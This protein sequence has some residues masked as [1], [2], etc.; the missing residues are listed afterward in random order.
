MMKIFILTGALILTFT[1]FSQRKFWYIA[2][3]YFINP[4]FTSKIDTQVFAEKKVKT[5]TIKRYGKKGKQFVVLTK[6]FNPKGQ[7]ISKKGGRGKNQYS[8]TYQYNDDGK[9]I[10]ETSTQ[11]G[12]VKVLT[13]TYN[14]NQ[15]VTQYKITR[16][17][18]FYSAQIS[19][20]DEKNRQILKENY[21]KDSITPNSSL[22]KIYYENGSL[23]TSISRRKGK[24]VHQWNYDCKPEGELVAQKKQS[25]ICINEELDENGNKVVWEKTLTQKGKVSKTK[26]VYLQ[27]S[28]LL[29]VDYFNAHDK[30]YLKTIH[31]VN[32]GVKR[33]I[34]NKKGEAVHSYESIMN[35]DKQPIKTI[36]NYKEKRRYIALYTYENQ[37]K[38]MAI[39]INNR[40][41][42]VAEYEYSFFE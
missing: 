20:Y 32:G 14:D 41:K 23:K 18:V 42:T 26:S 33:T 25:T 2:N 31:H 37:L 12:N 28:I 7:L 39:R 27:D 24:I 30:L 10:K 40:R 34:F 16:N 5:Q 21:W 36:L 3:G 17:N 4:S 38:K 1:S 8:T 11:K 19:Q 6:E 29:S 9:M 35:T 15:Q 13:I 22:E